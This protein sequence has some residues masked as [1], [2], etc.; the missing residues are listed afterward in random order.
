MRKITWLLLL[1]TL[2]KCD[3][4]FAD[5]IPFKD[6]VQIDLSYKT[7]GKPLFDSCG[8]I[9]GNFQTNKLDTFFHCDGAACITTD[10]FY[11]IK[12]SRA[13]PDNF[14]IIFYY[15]DKILTSPSLYKNGVNSYH[16]LL[17]T[18]SAVK[19]ITPV[20][21]TSYTNYLIAFL[22]TIILELLVGFLYFWRHKIGF[23]KL[24]YVVYINLLTHPLLW[25]A[26]A[27]FIGFFTGNIIGE[28]VVLV[29]EGLLLYKLLKP[30]LSISKSIWLSFQMN[31]ISFILGGLIYLIATDWK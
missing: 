28:P 24:K 6:K 17:I 16:L 11:T 8:V 2:F 7:S 13:I 1:I 3:K 25:L 9:Y 14:K 4:S 15:K 29:C 12:L 23:A 27:N 5:A 19:D 20:F 10:G 18:D 22:T 26:S 31:L 30:D 21:K